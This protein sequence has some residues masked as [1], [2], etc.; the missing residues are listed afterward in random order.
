M[1]DKYDAPRPKNVINFL[2]RDWI[3]K[4]NHNVPFSPSISVNGETYT[5]DYKNMNELFKFICSKMRHRPDSCK[6]YGI[7][8]E[9]DKIL[10]E[11]H[12]EYG[13]DG[14]FERSVIVYDKVKEAYNE[15]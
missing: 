14:S 5:G 10:E 11:Y 4:K 1:S 12:K 2:D 3:E 8:N 15:K 9:K 13:K 7:K 6:G